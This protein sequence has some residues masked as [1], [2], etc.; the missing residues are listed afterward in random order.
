[1]TIALSEATGVRPGMT[2]TAQ[3]VTDQHD[4]AV[5]VPNKAVTRSGSSRVVQVVTSNGTESRSVQVGLSNDSYTEITSGLSDGETVAV[6][7]TTTTARASVPGANTS[8]ATSIGGLSGSSQAQP[9]PQPQPPAGM[10]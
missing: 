7:G 1:M 4:D 9:Q 8:G 10:P 6:S 2:A 5:L 3:I